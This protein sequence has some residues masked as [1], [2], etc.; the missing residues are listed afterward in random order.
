[1]PLY[2][3]RCDQCR[4]RFTMMVG[5]VAGSREQ[6]CPACG[7]SKLTK[8]MS[9]FGTPRSEDQMLDDLADVDKIGDIEEDPKKMKKWVR[10]MSHAMDDDLGDDL[11]EL[12]ETM[13]DPSAEES[14]GAGAAGGLDDTIY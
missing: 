9:R 8:L 13:D 11:D 6:A 7:S 10:E 12:L 14:E 3:Y 5:V 4:K 2:E 1:M